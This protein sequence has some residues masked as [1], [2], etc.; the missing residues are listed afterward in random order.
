MIPK[1]EW[2]P[3]AKRL[4]IGQ[5]L[6]VRHLREKR[7]NLII[8]NEN[9][10]YWCYC[11]RCKD[12]SV[13]LKEHVRFQEGVSPEA[14]RSDLTLPQDM[15]PVL[16][17][18]MLENA[19]GAFLAGKSMDF[20]YVPAD[21]LK[22]SASRKRLMVQVQGKWF[23]RDITGSAAQKWLSY[24]GAH[25][26][27]ERFKTNMLVAGTAI[28]VEDL[29]SYFKV[30]HC[31][32][33]TKYSVYCSL[34]TGMH[35]TLMQELIKFPRVLFFYDGDSAGYDGA[36]KNARR[37]KVFGPSTAALCAPPGLDPKDMT[38]EA[39]IKHIIGH[40]WTS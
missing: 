5:K 25:F 33:L 32:T 22:Y 26:V 3:K 20:M 30:K 19:I 12:G 39:I 34:G 7:A 28:V 24:N 6:R 23:G 18:E 8:A 17:E 15:R 4:A 14:H 10:K 1:E 9:D 13:Q 36:E 11:Q 21:T 35:G 38:Q 40:V 31:L 2:L 37:L 29:F 27:G 16:G